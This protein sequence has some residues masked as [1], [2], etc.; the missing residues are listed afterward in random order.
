MSSGHAWCQVVKVLRGHTWTRHLS[1]RGL[2]GGLSAELLS[3]LPG[4]WTARATGAGARGGV[5]EAGEQKGNPTLL[6]LRTVHPYLGCRAPSWRQSHDLCPPATDVLG[7][8][9][10]RP[11]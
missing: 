3:P 8:W 2:G 1:R 4:L 9:E 7:C 11:A 5:W 10:G 6:H